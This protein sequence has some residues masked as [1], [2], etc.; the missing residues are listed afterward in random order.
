MWLTN[1]LTRS[2]NSASSEAEDATCT[3]VTVAEVVSQRQTAIK[4]M[5]AS[6]A[7][8]DFLN[9][10]RYSYEEVRLM[11]LLRDLE[12]GISAPGGSTA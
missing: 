7:T 8:H 6:I 3:P 12:H 11:R 9:A 2:R 1:I 4:K 10:R 5:V